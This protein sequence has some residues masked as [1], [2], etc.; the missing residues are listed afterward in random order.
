LSPSPSNR[1]VLLVA[2]LSLGA[3]CREPASPPAVQA[4]P[5]RISSDAPGAPFD[6]G[7]VIRRVHFAYRQEGDAWTAGHSTWSARVTDGALTFTPRHAALAAPENLSG[8]GSAQKQLAPRVLT[9]APV[10][11]GPAVLSRGG[12]PLD[13]SAG[14][15]T[16]AQDGTLTL[17][18]DSVE[19]QLQNREDGIE[20]RWRFARLP[21]GQGDLLLRVPVRGLR[22]AGETAQ[23]VH[24][25]DASGLGVR[26]SHATWTDASGQRMQIRARPVAGAVEFQV[27]ATLLASATFPAM[28]APSISPEFGLDTPVT[29]PGGGRQ[30]AP[31]VATNGT[32]YLVVW[33]DDRGGDTD[34]YGARVSQAGAVLDPLGIPVAVAV[35]AQQTPAVAFD[36]T[37]YLVV[38]SDGRR[39]SGTD[40]YGARV[41]A[42]GTVLDPSGLPLATST[43]FTLLM[44]APA[45]AFDGA[46]YFIVWDE[47]IG[48][49]APTNLN[50]LR[51]SPA[52]AILTGPFVVSNAVGNQLA[53]ALAFDGTNFLAVWQDD[54]AGQNDI[55]AARVSTSGTVLDSAGIAVSATSQLQSN[56]TVEFNGTTYLVVWEDYRNVSTGADLYGARVA[57]NG[58]VLDASGQPLI[59]AASNQTQ[60]ALA[61]LGSQYL[62]AWQDLR[63]GN[64]DV[65]AARVD[66][67]GSVLDASGLPVTTAPGTQGSV[68]LAATGTNALLAWG[69]DRTADIVGARLSATGTVLDPSGVTIS[70]STNSET[71]PAVAFDGTNYLAVWQDNRGNGFDLYGVRVSATGTVLDS[72]GVSISAAN[73]HQRNPAVG[74]DGTNYLVVWEDT[75]NGPASDIFGARVSQAGTV[76]DASG[77]PLCQRF[78]PQEHPALAFDGT[79]Y[80]VVWE[81]SGTSAARDIYGTRV[82]KAGAVLD[83]AFVGISTDSNDQTSPALA[84]DGTNYLVAW[85]DFRNNSTSDVYGA[86]VSRSGV[87]LDANGVQLAGGSESQT[88]AALAFDG[89]N[90]L[91]VW[92]DYQVYPSANLYARRVRTAGTPIDATPIAVSAAPGHQQQASVVYDGTDFLIAWQDAR[93]GTNLDVYTGRVSRAGVA[94]DGDGFILSANPSDESAVSLASGGAQGALAV[95][96]VTDAS[97]GSNV[98][99]LKARRLLP[100]SST[101][102]PPT[103]QPQSATTDEDVALPLELTG[104]DAEGGA[105]SYAV[106]TPPSHGALT[107]TAPKL[108][109]VPALNYN[110][111]DSFAFTVS[112]GQATSAPGTVSITVTAVNDPPVASA[113]SVTTVEETA[114]TITLTGS[115]AENDPLSFTVV[116]NPSHGTLTGTPPNF[117]YTPALNYSGPDS[118]TFTV[119]DGQVTSAP[120]TVSLTVTPVNDAPVANSRSLSTPEDTALPLTLTGTD[121]DGDSLS[122]A[123]ASQPSHGTLTGT[124]PNLLYTPA[125]N[126]NGPDSFTFT[127]SDGKET[128]VPGTISLSIAPVN[129]VPVAAARS[130]STA[131]DTAAAITLS[132]SDTD[133]D[134]LSFAIAS[135]PAHGTLTGTP[136][137]LLYTPAPDYFG[138]DSFTFTVSDGQRTSDPATVSLTITS[139]NDAPVA[140]ARSLNGVED[141]A[142]PLTLSGTDADGDPLSFALASQPSHGTL[143]GTPPNLTYTPTTS[144]HGSD[145]F[146]F[147]ASD[148]VLTSAPATVSV[149]I[150]SVNNAPV[151]S[152]RAVTTEEDTAA[153][154]TLTGSD[155]DGD[156]LSFTI[157]SPPAHGTLTGKAPSLTYTPAANYNGLDSFTFTATDGQFTSG[158]ATVSITI[159]AVN[160]AP[161]A[162]AQSISL[163]ED[164]AQAITL[165]AVDPEGSAVSFALAS[166]PSHGT[167]TG[168]P[169]NLT[170]MPA[171]NYSG[172]DSFTFTA[173][174]GVAIS[175][176]TLVSLTVTEVNDAPVAQAKTLTVPAG[177]PT[178]LYLDAMDTDD[179]ELTFAIVSYPETGKLTGTPPDLHYTAPQSFTGTT[180]FTFSV[181]DGKAI[182]SAEVQL[183]VEKRSL[184][185]SAA[186]DTQRPAEGQ[187]VRFYANAVDEAGAPITLQWDFG[188]GQTSQEDLPAHAFSAPGTYEVRLKASTATEEATASLRMRVRSSAP[189]TLTAADTDSAPT[190][191]GVEG[192]ALSF[193]FSEPQ[194]ELTYTWDFGDG[195]P[196]TTGTTASHTWADDGR[197]TLKVTAVNILTGDSRE[198]R[199]NVR[200]HNTPPVPMPQERLSA[201][202][203]SVIA[204]QF[205]GSDAAG[206]SDPLRWELVTGEGSLTPEGSFTWTPSKEG[207]ATVMTKVIDGDGGESRF[208]FQLGA[209]NVGP[210]PSEGCGC[211]TGS[212]DASGALALGLLLLSLVATGRVRRRRTD[213]R[214]R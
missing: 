58:S 49:S 152:A 48:F 84:F 189:I 14:H 63:S 40:I 109:Y 17:T 209:G 33:S 32:D 64:L 132:G 128:S 196:T 69:D 20:Q 80:L 85:S 107:G 70:L 54:R 137:N 175:A 39:G 119:S 105:L 201:S 121:V 73:G 131:E 154:I 90:Y 62:L 18:R 118:F 3:A 117:T 148:G 93:S 158:P 208:A 141:T 183:T 81:D 188:D 136:P 23:G 77:L 24:F 212:G 186:A 177:S 51:V 164:T 191:V 41:S 155:V 182:S 125:Q 112:D 45:I 98:Q 95:Y 83:S 211:G 15:G 206:A 181:S 55:Y 79:N 96:Q 101:N 12:V 115:D 194:A 102:T 35:N 2:L 86:R 180:R 103:A 123:I 6:L 52:G 108:T 88:D 195:T 160:D 171:T 176:P 116:S 31:A 42:A 7:S 169:P 179:E 165:I 200:I 159:T 43:V 34:V 4:P 38:W 205:A 30:T 199:R 149:F 198:F 157:V 134:P 28:L 16:V 74:F 213:L 110:G 184:T 197:F 26:Y 8:P 210:E 56:P 72:S 71:N 203:G 97:L 127:V 9:G 5:P 89:T 146:T 173:S 91:L 75:R 13:S 144:Y 66:A 19:E 21:E 153:G 193:S 129:D 113:Q 145:S 25:A 170:Y 11:L 143:T 162:K 104:T 166:Q 99:R 67:A 150:G 53:S 22:L 140:T 161:D 135:L 124:L 168:T 142:I 147:T 126:Y 10:T 29:D 174:D 187:Q 36:G 46:N 111:P 92:S 78:S 114:K 122:F 202:P 138:P 178:A 50:G 57:P 59:Q 167:L 76:L 163:R 204:V 156:E 207:L 185:V 82:S 37:N 44:S 214:P 133:G 192:S 1:I 130:L 120:S 47:K 27:P 106:V 65:Y 60:P 190:V 94:L 139:V 172:P 87:L 61:R 151:A 68:A 100:G